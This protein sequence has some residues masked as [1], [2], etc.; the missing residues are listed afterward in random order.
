A[1]SQ[2]ARGARLLLDLPHGAI[3]L[4]RAQLHFRKRNTR[5]RAALARGERMGEEVGGSIDERDGGTAIAAAFPLATHLCQSV[6]AQLEFLAEPAQHGR[7]GAEIV[8]LERAGDVIRAL[9]LGAVIDEVILA[10]RRAQF[11]HRLG[12]DA[13]PE[14]RKVTDVAMDLAA[15]T[16]FGW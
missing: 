2:T 10:V 9:A 1:R 4:R 16:S 14:E 3:S 6:G 5:D 12:I 11:L 13:G 15:R 7:F 8:V